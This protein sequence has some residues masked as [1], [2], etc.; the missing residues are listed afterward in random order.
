MKKVTPSL[1]TIENANPNPNDETGQYPPR[2]QSLPPTFK[3]IKATRQKS[4][5]DKSIT[6]TQQKFPKFLNQPT[7][8]IAN[9]FKKNHGQK[10]RKPQEKPK[11]K[12]NSRDVICQLPCI[13]PENDAP[14]KKSLVASAERKL[15][16]S[17]SNRL[18]HGASSF[19]TFKDLY[20]K[21]PITALINLNEQAQIN[22][23]GTN[24]NGRSTS[25]GKVKFHYLAEN[26]ECKQC[27]SKNKKRIAEFYRKNQDKINLFSQKKRYFS[28]FIH[29]PTKTDSK[30]FEEVVVVKD[31]NLGSAN[32]S[33][34]LTLFS[35]IKLQST[36]N[37]AKFVP[38]N[39]Y[40]FEAKKKCEAYDFSPEES[41]T[42]HDAY[43]LD[44]FREDY[45]NDTVSAQSLAQSIP[46]K[47]ETLPNLNEKHLERVA[48]KHLTAIKPRKKDMFK[49]LYEI[50]PCGVNLRDND[51]NNV[52][53][54]EYQSKFKKFTFKVNK[55]KLSESDKAMSREDKCKIDNE[56]EKCKN[57]QPS[58]LQ[59]PVQGA[60]ITVQHN[61]IVVEYL[62][63]NLAKK[64]IVDDDKNDRKRLPCKV[65]KTKRDTS[66]DHPCYK[67]NPCSQKDSNYDKNIKCAP[68]VDIDYFKTKPIGKIIE[69]DGGHIKVR[70][71][72]EAPSV[73]YYRQDTHENSEKKFWS[74]LANKNRQKVIENDKFI[75]ISK[76]RTEKYKELMQAKQNREAIAKEPSTS[77][78]KDSLNEKICEGISSLSKVELGEQSKQII[79]NAIKQMIEP[80]I[81]KEFL[82]YE[83][84]KYAL[85]RME[86]RL[87]LTLKSLKPTQSRFAGGSK[88]DPKYKRYPWQKISIGEQ[89]K[90]PEMVDPLEKALDKR[91]PGRKIAIRSPAWSRT[92]PQHEPLKHTIFFSNK[93]ICDDETEQV[94][95]N[96]KK[97]DCFA[98][99]S[100][101][102]K[103]LAVETD[104]G[105]VDL[106]KQTGDLQGGTVNCR[107]KKDCDD[108]CIPKAAPCTWANDIPMNVPNCDKNKCPQTPKLKLWPPCSKNADTAQPT[109]VFD[110]CDEKKCPKV[111]PVQ[112]IQ[113]PCPKCKP[114]VEPFKPCVK[115]VSS[116]E[117]PKHH[118]FEGMK[119]IIKPDPKKNEPCPCCRKPIAEAFI[120]LTK[121]FSKQANA[122]PKEQKETKDCEVKN[123]Y[124]DSE[125][126]D[127]DMQET[128]RLKEMQEEMLKQQKAATC[129]KGVLFEKE[130]KKDW[131]A[132]Q[133]DANKMKDKQTI[134][135]DK[136]NTGPKQNSI[137]SEQLKLATA[138]NKQ[139]E[140]R[141]APA[142]ISHDQSL[143]ESCSNKISDLCMMI[144]R[145]NKSDN[146]PQIELSTDLNKIANRF[147]CKSND[148]QSR[149]KSDTEEIL[150]QLK[151]CL[152]R[153]KEKGIAADEG[154][155]NKDSCPRQKK[156]R[157]AE[158]KGSSQDPKVGKLND[159][160]KKQ[161]SNPE[162]VDDKSGGHCEKTREN[163]CQKRKE[164][165]CKKRDDPC[166]KYREDPCKKK[167]DPCKKPREDPC[168]KKDDPC[169][170][171]REDPCK[172]KDDP[173]KKPRED[174]CQIP[175][176]DPC[177]K[178]DD[179]CKKPSEDP[180]KKRQDDPCQKPKDICKKKEDDPC[181]RAKE[182]PCK[183]KKSEPCI[184]CKYE[185][186]SKK[187]K[188]KTKSEPCIPCKYEDYSK[189]GK[190]DS[191]KDDS[192]KTKTLADC[193]DKRLLEGMS[194]YQPKS[195]KTNKSDCKKAKD[196]PCKANQ[197][198]KSDRSAAHD[199]KLKKISDCIKQKS[200]GSIVADQQDDH[201]KKPSKDSGRINPCK[202]NSEK[203]SSGTS[204]D[205]KLKKISD[206]VKQKSKELIIADHKDGHSKK[207]KT[208]P[209]KKNDDPCKPKKEDPCKKNDDPC[210][211]KKEDP[212]KK[213][214]DPCKSKKD[215][216]CKKMDDPCKPK[217]A[218]CC[219]KKDNPCKSN[220]EDP[221]K[222]KDDPC[223]RKKEDFCK[224]K[225]DPCKSK[226]EDPCKQK[227]KNPCTSDKKDLCKAKQDDPCEN[228]TGRFADCKAMFLGCLI[229]ANRCDGAMNRPI[230]TAKAT[231]Q[232]FKEKYPWVLMKKNKECLL[233][234]ASQC[235]PKNSNQ[236][237]DFHKGKAQSDPCF[238]HR[239]A[240]EDIPCLPGDKLLKKFDTAMNKKPGSKQDPCQTFAP[241]PAKELVALQL[242]PDRKRISIKCLLPNRFLS[243]SSGKESKGCKTPKTK[244]KN[245]RYP[246][247]VN[248]PVMLTNQI[249]YYRSA[250]CNQLKK[251]LGIICD[252]AYMIVGDFNPLARRMA[253]HTT[254]RVKRS[255]SEGYDG[256]TNQYVASGS[257]STCDASKNS[258]TNEKSTCDSLFPSRSKV[259]STIGIK[260]FC[261][262]KLEMS[263]SVQQPKYHQELPKW[264][265]H[266]EI[267]STNRKSSD[268][269]KTNNKDLEAPQKA[270]SDSTK[271]LTDCQK[272]CSKKDD[273]KMAAIC[274]IL[275][276]E[277]E[278]KGSTEKNSV[279]IDCQ[280]KTKKSI[281]KSM[282][283]TGEF[284]EK[285]CKSKEEDPGIKSKQSVQ[286]MK[287]KDFCEDKKEDPC[288]PKNESSCTKSEQSLK[289]K[290]DICVPKKED[291]CAS[292][293][294][295]QDPINRKLNQ[296][297]E[298]RSKQAIISDQKDINIKKPTQVPCEKS[299]QS[300]ESTK[301]IGKFRK[302]KKEYPWVKSKKSAQV[303]I[304]TD[305]KEDPC[306]RKKETPCAI[307]EQ[308]AESMKQK[309]D[310]CVLKKEDSSAPSGSSQDP[311]N[312]TLN[313]CIATVRSKQKMISDQK[314]LHTE[315]SK[316]ALCKKSEQRDQSIKQKKAICAPKK[317]DLCGKSKHKVPLTRKN[318]CQSGNSKQNGPRVSLET[319]NKEISVK[320][321]KRAAEYC[322]PCK[323]KKPKK[324]R[325][326]SLKGIKTQNKKKPMNCQRKKKKPSVFT[327]R[328]TFLP[329]PKV[330]SITCTKNMKSD[331]SVSDLLSNKSSN[332]RE[333]A[334]KSTDCQKSSAAAQKSPEE[335]LKVK[336]ATNSNEISQCREVSQKS[337]ATGRK[338]AEDFLKVEF[339]PTSHDMSQR[340][341]IEPKSTAEQGRL[342]VVNEST[343]LR[344]GL[345]CIS[346]TLP[347]TKI[348]TAVETCASSNI[349]NEKRFLVDKNDNESLQFFKLARTS[350][351]NDSTYVSSKKHLD[352]FKPYAN[353]SKP[354]TDLLCD[355]TTISNAAEA[356]FVLAKEY[357]CPQLLQEDNDKKECYENSEKKSK[358]C[359]LQKGIKNLT[360]GYDK[361][362]HEVEELLLRKNTFVAKV[363]KLGLGEKLVCTCD[364]D[365]KLVDDYEDEDFDKDGVERIVK[366]AVVTD[367]FD[368]SKLVCVEILSDADLQK[369]EEEQ[370]KKTE[371]GK[372]VKIPL[373][374][375]I[376]NKLVCQEK[377][378]GKGFTCEMMTVEEIRVPSRKKTKNIKKPTRKVLSYIEL[379]KKCREKGHME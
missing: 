123:R 93:N 106:C 68:K 342:S 178:K 257:K 158:G 339:A 276:N 24:F 13:N 51:P 14:K 79:A 310:I 288:Q 379:M 319:L 285:L 11:S 273:S 149:S 226:K 281:A 77:H 26:T 336:C 209:C 302:A 287:R 357:L 213:K 153:L 183:E 80:I 267:E 206:C 155:D 55:N 19:G 370:L 332:F 272:K 120:R 254:S 338:S 218:D 330:Q 329:K 138:P 42:F 271:P 180:C 101:K 12:Q 157:C 203:D 219:K 198:R 18:L 170:K 229:G 140:M 83:E 33:N 242:I 222:K 315:K 37:P 35:L 110:G 328:E 173:C 96:S 194:L 85:E 9:K 75:E 189:K 84:V 264:C 175:R 263:R 340:K 244:D 347:L 76:A 289:Q 358:D 311:R 87:T 320:M 266:T 100:Q 8:K 58:G 61:D 202:S 204:Q 291:L 10:I 28:S 150:K 32:P 98:E 234:K 192:S 171:P 295:S 225:D 65:P 322:Q 167:D 53:R 214:E 239:K 292:S 119:E 156:D 301:K 41:L 300:V 279:L 343:Q 323:S 298:I 27:I 245:S 375:V 5:K 246:W 282:E 337:S 136:C 92:E 103:Q 107:K 269:L 168:K 21:S 210:K 308:S 151:D 23:N 116:C 230:E 109:T 221:C 290:K 252:K 66:K 250:S 161:K 139:Y 355:R 59:N 78:P 39:L 366:C 69:D 172:K 236:K 201:G 255:K 277:N 309:Q 133:I 350:R 47:V 235:I 270:Q 374:K 111:K 159:C 118:S 211:P 231:T 327:A 25:K 293:G 22:S 354:K 307:S 117:K 115:N 353:L 360:V 247:N 208:D 130:T 81:Q 74:D 125:I 275:I 129:N 220:R 112:C 324:R 378:I 143:M 248:V 304:C 105:N 45:N 200:K 182:D 278:S 341:K 63:L 321:E 348:P 303:D 57:N 249:N 147:L 64:K 333:V 71:L 217:K 312:S 368:K 60:P 31:Q 185:D 243:F 227:K 154:Q 152:N 268:S 286:V 265:R 40:K 38:T 376:S 49:K 365:G 351:E 166:K 181:M 44:M 179:P 364:K 70:K 127:K 177:K 114:S 104:C 97:V 43:P 334:R 165:P 318:E 16:T 258:G 148:G 141:A 237:I 36:K 294:S 48:Q 163:P 325:V 99:L 122:I 17:S 2:S 3:P 135:R 193:M 346:E 363:Q 297:I 131:Q 30:K 132:V 356:Q 34:A 46:K 314:D 174:R 56:T 67:D 344:K 121:T 352:Y 62:G 305:K 134:K 164:D 232:H 261:M 377:S 108:P 20:K 306:K 102:K 184:P 316:Q 240:K 195:A 196:D 128:K 369:L 89:T 73:R 359:S 145:K 367:K 233:T 188:A 259:D 262:Q 176:E 142:K 349:G 50:T 296:F 124:C 169:K 82:R 228:Q 1:S 215:D 144:V 241:F 91:E 90:L 52:A 274:Q 205:P 186:Y 326:I 362:D 88:T 223:G 284:Y 4:F 335:F 207:P 137:L 251:T 191:C 224:K 190:S 216:P 15:H 95:K 238:Q 94:I 29:K 212:C 253:F 54:N 361:I 7:F 86:K 372:Q 260:D 371:K 126:L 72:E 6:N 160:V 283:T 345:E 199:P 299:D 256:N 146:H 162:I 317:E 187:S 280:K 373:F 313:K 113:T 197:E 331:R